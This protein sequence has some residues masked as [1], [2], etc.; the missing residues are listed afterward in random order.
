MI[1]CDECRQWYHVNCIKVD[2]KFLNNSK[3]KWCCSKCQGYIYTMFANLEY[4]II[5]IER[6]TPV[7]LKELEATLSDMKVMLLIRYIT[8]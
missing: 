3:L 4:N 5:I 2:A 7:N 6:T 8:I 1:Q